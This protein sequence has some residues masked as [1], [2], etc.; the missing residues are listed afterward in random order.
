M[1]F[2]VGLFD[3]NDTLFN[4][5]SRARQYGATPT[6]TL[7]TSVHKRISAQKKPAYKHLHPQRSATPER[8]YYDLLPYLNTLKDSAIFKR[9]ARHGDR[10]VIIKTHQ[11]DTIATLLKR[12]G[13]QHVNLS[14]D[15][16]D[17]RTNVS[18]A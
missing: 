11:P 12:A 15:I 2:V 10:L 4:A 17:A 5:V 14:P 16:S 13:S 9:A 1:S 6:A 18:Q 8:T 3:T 7:N